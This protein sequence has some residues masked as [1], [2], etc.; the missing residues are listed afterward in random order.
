MLVS[1]NGVIRLVPVNE[2]SP[3]WPDVLSPHVYAML[4]ES[5]ANVNASPSATIVRAT[6]EGTTVGERTFAPLEE[7]PSCVLPLSPHATRFGGRE[8]PTHV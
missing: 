3:S 6:G 4:V 2:A 8:M 7:M 5:T 1:A